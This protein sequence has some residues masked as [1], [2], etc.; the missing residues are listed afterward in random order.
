LLL[1]SKNA[2][3]KVIFTSLTTNRP[4]IPTTYPGG[5]VVTHT[6][7]PRGEVASSGLDGSPLASYT[8]TPVSRLASKSLE[9]RQM[10]I[11]EVDCHRQPA[12]RDERARTS[13]WLSETNLYDYRN[14]VYSPD[15]GRFMQ[16]DPV[17]FS[18]GDGNLYRCVGNNPIN[19]WDSLGLSQESEKKN[20]T[21]KNWPRPPGPGPRPKPG[22]SDDKGRS[23][24]LV[25][26]GNERGGPS[27][28]DGY[29]DLN[30]TLGFHGLTSGGGVLFNQDGFALYFGGGFGTPGLGGSF[31]AGTGSL[32][33]SGDSFSQ[34]SSSAVISFSKGRNSDGTSFIE[35][36]MGT[37]SISRTENHVLFS[38]RQR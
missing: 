2:T 32:P 24:T 30:F 26:T 25:A 3:P 12:G 9:P 34:F 23:T 38:T 33:R 29:G 10:G 35:A 11:C 16:T 7:T 22:P 1:Q 13:Q 36:G 37:P 14:R 15:L 6:Y 4:P 8:Y 27:R 31:S 19:R 5:H 18:A 17:R 21:E 28:P 20:S